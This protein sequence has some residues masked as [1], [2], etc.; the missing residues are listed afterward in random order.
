MLAPI[1]LTATCTGSLLEPTSSP[2]VRHSM[3]SLQFGKHSL[4]FWSSESP[5]FKA[6]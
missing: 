6:S 2:S 1:S 5:R 3:R 4:M